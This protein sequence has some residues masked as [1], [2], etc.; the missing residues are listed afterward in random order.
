MFFWCGKAALVKLW[1]QRCLFYFFLEQAKRHPYFVWCR[2]ILWLAIAY[3]RELRFD[4]SG[5]KMFTKGARLIIRLLG[6]SRVKIL[7]C[8]CAFGLAR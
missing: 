7:E 3:G 5:R 4:Y 2:R 6:V 8:T 1:G